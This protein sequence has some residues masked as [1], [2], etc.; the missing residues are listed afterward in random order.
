[1]SPRDTQP[2]GGSRL[3]V[4]HVGDYQPNGANGVDR[5]IAG[6]VTF[7]PPSD[8]DVELWR[9]ERGLKTPYLTSVDGIDMWTLPA[10]KGLH[11]RVFPLPRRTRQWIR[12]QADRVDLIHLH[13]V[14]R[15]LN[16]AFAR[17]RISYV[18]T[19][20]GGYAPQ[21][22]AGGRRRLKTLWWYSIERSLV[23]N[24]RLVHLMSERELADLQHL[25]RGRLRSSVVAPNGIAPADFRQSYGGDSNGYLL[26]LG[27]IAVRYKGL[28]LLFEGYALAMSKTKSLPPLLLVGP[29]HDGGLATLRSLAIRLGIEGHVSFEQSATGDAKNT[30]FRGARA[31]VHSSRSEGLPFAVLEALAV[32]LPALL[33]TGTNLRSLTEDAD[34]AF[35]CDDTPE[36]I[37]EALLVISGTSAER[38]IEMGDNAARLIRSQ[39]GWPAICASMASAYRA[40]LQTTGQVAG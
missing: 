3:R 8:I 39:F 34:C 26:F 18:L 24:A 13:S 17:Q 7:L 25:T 28:D 5:A 36:S 20:H 1:M 11:G 19:P 30:A 32:G 9:V 38:L 37:A 14:F 29:D 23:T 2:A 12:S 10:R 40:A 35:G 4:A 16:V 15:P 31:F 21:V 6:L 27:R 33:T 22:M